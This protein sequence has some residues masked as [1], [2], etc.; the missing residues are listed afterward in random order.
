VTGT[1][2]AADVVGPAGQGIAP[3][4]FGELVRA[5]KA[6]LTYSNVHTQSFAAGEI[7]GQIK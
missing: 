5:M 7:R 2:V 6:G 4:E 3:G 1:V